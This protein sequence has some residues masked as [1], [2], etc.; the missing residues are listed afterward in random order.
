MKFSTNST[1]YSIHMKW[2]SLLGLALFHWGYVEIGIQFVETKSL[3]Y[4]CNAMCI[5]KFL[6]TYRHIDSFS[7]V[8]NYRRETVRFT[9][10]ND[11][12]TLRTIDHVAV[13]LMAL[14]LLNMLEAKPGWRLS[15]RRLLVHKYLSYMFH[16]K[17]FSLKRCNS[18]K[19]TQ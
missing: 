12:M 1:S 10:K 16:V 7:L 19:Q 14:S 15:E 2:C 5:W 8:K 9:I 4:C 3:P 18:K 6:E 11:F 17:S 13:M